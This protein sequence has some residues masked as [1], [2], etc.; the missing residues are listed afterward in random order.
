MPSLNLWDDYPEKPGARRIEIDALAV[1]DA[2][3][4]LCEAKNSGGLNTNDKT[5]LVSAVNRIRPNVLLL[6]CMDTDSRRLAAD[7]DELRDQMP[8]DLTIEVI[9]FAPER[10]RRDPILPS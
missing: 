1:V 8:G 10:L 7:A 6:I 9:G 5:K 3:L 2:T 4:Y